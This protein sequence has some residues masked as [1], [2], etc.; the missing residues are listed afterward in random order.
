MSISGNGG[1]RSGEPPLEYALE[2]ALLLV[3]GH[4]LVQLQH[5]LA[6]VEAQGRDLVVE[7]GPVQEAPADP[8]F[9]SP[10]AACE[11]SGRRYHRALEGRPDDAALALVERVAV[12]R[13]NRLVD[14]GLQ[15]VAGREA[16]LDEVGMMDV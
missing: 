1:L 14:R 15:V 6:P 7:V 8:G 12:G 5:G 2:L 9:R 3:S 16:H 4:G 11:C 10:R 13:A